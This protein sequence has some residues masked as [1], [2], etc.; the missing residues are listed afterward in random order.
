MTVVLCVDEEW[1][2][3]YEE[4]NQFYEEWEKYYVVTY[5]LGAGRSLALL[6]LL[7][8][9]GAWVYRRLKEWYLNRNERNNGERRRLLNRNA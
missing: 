2:K 3:Y 7:I 1:K 5:V 8:M 6:L 4:W 9:G